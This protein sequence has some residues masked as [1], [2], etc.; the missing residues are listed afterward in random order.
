MHPP[1][2]HREPLWLNSAVWEPG[3]SR[4][5]DD[6]REEPTCGANELEELSYA[7]LSECTV[8]PALVPSE[9]CGITKSAMISAERATSCPNKVSINV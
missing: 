1:A 7:V 9:S 5:D 4:D 6:P 2:G 3:A 8:F